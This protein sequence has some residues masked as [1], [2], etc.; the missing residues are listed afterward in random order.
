[1]I[2]YLS[3]IYPKIHLHILG[4]LDNALK[5][6]IKNYNLTNC[7]FYGRINYLKLTSYYNNC[8]IQIRPAIFDPCPNVV[9]EGLAS[10][11]PVITPVQS[12][13]YEL[14]GKNRDWSINEDVKL[15]YKKLYYTKVL[16]EIPL[17]KYA[18]KV[19]KYL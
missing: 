19:I 3:N 6:I 15:E 2:N 16:S 1:M 5:E 11:L 8:D 10:G 4:E 7:I 18:K 17:E 14:I 12:G 9:V 13:A